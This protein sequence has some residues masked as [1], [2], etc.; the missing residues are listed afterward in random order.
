MKPDT[1]AIY[2]AR[3]LMKVIMSAK[4]TEEENRRRIEAG[5]QP[6]GYT[7]TSFSSRLSGKGRWMSLSFFTEIHSSPDL[8]RLYAALIEVPG[9]RMVL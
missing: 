4:E 7:A 6:L 3:V 2:P 1:S 9:T 5:I 8:E